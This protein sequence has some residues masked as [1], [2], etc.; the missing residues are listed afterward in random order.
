MRMTRAIP[1]GSTLLIEAIPRIDIVARLGG[2][3]KARYLWN[4]AGNSRAGFLKII[5]GM[6]SSVCIRG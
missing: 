2:G 1:H 5:F 3:S 4:L 6:A